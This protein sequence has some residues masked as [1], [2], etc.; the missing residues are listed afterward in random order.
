MKNFLQK[1]PPKR[2]TNGFKSA[3]E[4]RKKFLEARKDANRKYTE[5]SKD[6]N[7]PGKNG[8]LKFVIYEGNNCSI[9]RKAMHARMSQADS[10]SPLIIGS[11]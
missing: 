5:I 1:F 4:E 11:R 7:K 9:I 3:E 10:D 6:N 8:P 2:L